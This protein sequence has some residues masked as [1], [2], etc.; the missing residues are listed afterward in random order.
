MDAPAPN[1]GGLLPS[2]VSLA[3][4]DPVSQILTGVVMVAVLYFIMAAAEF[5]Y[6]SWYTMYKDRVEL[7][8]NTYASGSKVYTAIQNPK[9]KNSKTV[10]FSDN[11]R[12]G[13]EFSYAMFCYLSSET[14]TGTQE[15][16]HILHKGYSRPYPLLGPGIFAW[17]H[18]NCLR[19]YVNCFKNW[20]NFVEVENIPVEKWF[21]LVVSVKG[22]QVYVYIN[23]NIKVKVTT[24]DSTPPYQNYGDVYLFNS[25]TMSL[26]NTL[27]SIAG[28]T[29]FATTT[30][31]PGQNALTNLQFT[32]AA[33]GY[34]SRVFYFGY[35]LTY[36]EI[37]SLMNMGPSNI[38]EGVDL[39]I[40]PYL[41]DRWWTDRNS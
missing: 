37:Q 20:S 40:S 7:F 3:G 4:T 14:F 11:Q 8:P 33:K 29:A 28:D 9:N 25:R 1:S 30:S 18:K 6:G 15:L 23:G 31:V 17:G 39:S 2:S 24:P 12:Y 10:Y 21:H 32:G 19:I 38:M 34:V 5:I 41:A 27:P 35:A 22:S 16:K 36:T 26:S 13:I